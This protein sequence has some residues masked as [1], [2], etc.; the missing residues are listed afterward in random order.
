MASN[1]KYFLSSGFLDDLEDEDF[2]DDFDVAVDEVN[3]PVGVGAGL[4]NCLDCNKT[5]KTLRG[6]E[7]H[8][9]TKHGPPRVLKFD[10]VILSEL[11]QK[12][13]KK[14]YED[15]C[16][17][18]A[19]RSSV[20]DSCSIAD[21]EFFV[22]E[23][24]KICEEFN[25]HNDP[26]QFFE[27]FFARITTKAN[28]FIK[29]LPLGAATSTMLLLGETVFAYLKSIYC[30]AD[31]VHSSSP[32]TKDERDALQYLA[33][34]VVHK[35]LKKFK[36]KK[37]KSEEN[38]SII[39]ALEG[40]VDDSRSQ[41][42]VESLSRGGLTSVSEECEQIFYKTEELFRAKTSV[43]NLHN[44]DIEEIASNLM[45]QPD[46]ISL[47]N[48]IVINSGSDI[49]TEIK[50]NLFE[51]MIKLYLRVRSFSLARD[52][53]AKKKKASATSKSLR[54]EMKKAQQLKETKK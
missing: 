24:T 20:M 54:K 31:V 26:E 49:D 52:I 39:L 28:I 19:L 29:T 8:S 13:C 47:T 43:V 32:I 9:K 5:Y 30:D 17:S 11:F 38:Q 41:K 23:V 18:V 7:R 36:Y 27:L 25:E 22:G 3:I 34:Y 53:T 42:L 40:M 10:G 51:K 12:A 44:I 50:N 35:F 48:S 16:W 15:E 46:I 37:S 33:G 21:W 1:Y 45:T 14:V 6:L 2:E 4:H